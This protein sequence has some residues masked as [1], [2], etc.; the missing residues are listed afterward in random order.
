MVNRLNL[1]QRLDSA[2]AV[3]LRDDLSRAEGDDLALD[4]SGVEVLGG[5]CLELLM[6]AGQVWA[7]AD[8]SFSIESPSPNFADNLARFG[9]SPE[10]LSSGARP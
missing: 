5:L 4:A 10:T 6:C 8:R 9:L 2:A 7:A 1:N 3:R